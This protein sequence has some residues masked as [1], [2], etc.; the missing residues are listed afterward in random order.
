MAH[1]QCQSCGGTY[2][3]VLPDG[4]RYFHVCPPLS[5]VELAAAVKDGRVTLHTGETVA[6]A[7]QRRTYERASKRDERAVQL[8][9][10]DTPPQIVSEGKGTRPVPVDVD[11]APVVVV[12]EADGPV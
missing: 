10:P 11:A 5:L 3:T 9:R 4:L 6:D 2:D 7:F 1:L 8:T 12:P